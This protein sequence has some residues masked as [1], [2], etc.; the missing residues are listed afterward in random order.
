[1]VNQRCQKKISTTKSLFQISI[2]QQKNFGFG[3]SPHHVT[4]IAYEVKYHPDKSALLKELLVRASV[5]DNT[6][7]FDSIIHFI[8]Y[9]LINVSD[10]NTVK[11]Q[12]IQR[13]QFI[14][15]T[16]IIPIHNVDVDTMYSDLKDKLENLPSVTNIKKTYLSSK[17]E[18]CLVITTKKQ[19]EQARHDID[20]L[21]NN[22]TFPPSIERPGRSNHYN[23]N[24]SL[25]SYAATLQKESTT[26]EQQYHHAPK[27]AFKQYVDISYNVEDER[28]FPT[29]KKKTEIPTNDLASH[30]TLTTSS[31][32]NDD[33][34]IQLSFNHDEFLKQMKKRIINYE[35]KL[36]LA[37]IRKLRNN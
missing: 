17:S 19:K 34:T 12:I 26:R 31:L 33:N 21:I 25:V 8:P 4:T 28:L 14:H 24:T 1:M 13:N 37:T 32:S 27:Y 2:Y 11:H 15:N 10:S 23:I 5:L 30:A 9:G 7:P 22:T 18:K 36:K 35:A 29:L 16:S 20:N 6:P 3:N